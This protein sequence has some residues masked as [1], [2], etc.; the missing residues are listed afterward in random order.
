MK[1]TM[2]KIAGILIPTIIALFFFSTLAS[3][4]VTVIPKTS[5]TGAW[6][7][8]SV[9][10]PVEKEMATTKFTVKVPAGLEV[11]SYQPVPGWNYSTEKDANGKVET[12]TF[13]ATGEG[14]LP[15]QFQT[16]VF[17]AKNPDK[18]VKAAWDAFQYYKDGSVVEWTGDEGSDS[19]HAITDI[20][21]ATTTDQT[22]AQQN[23]K[24]QT[25]KTD[26]TKTTESTNTL[27][28]LLSGL[29]VLLSLAALILAVRKK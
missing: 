23:E 28:L 16:F 26:N 11:M 19:P 15:G 27:P 24:T 8:Y 7:T 29:A 2:K 22:Q 10:V 3:A 17:V 6:E 18:A 4:H 9:K 1:K 14:I 13:S 12:F 21:T 20:V 5:T 25:E